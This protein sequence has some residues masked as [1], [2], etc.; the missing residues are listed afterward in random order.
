MN[1][2]FILEFINWACLVEQRLSVFVFLWYCE[3][4]R[5]CYLHKPYRN[6]FHI[7]IPVAVFQFKPNDGLRSSMT[8]DQSN[9][10]VVAKYA[11]IVC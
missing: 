5:D 2:I 9:Y 4:C 8:L 1:Y 6:Q 10:L 3:L 11:Y 7:M